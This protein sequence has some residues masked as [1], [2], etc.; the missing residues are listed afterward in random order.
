V[1]TLTTTAAVRSYWGS[2][3][4]EEWLRVWL[5]GGASEDHDAILAARLDDAEAV[6]LSMLSSRY[7]REQLLAA[8]PPQMLVQLIMRQARRELTAKMANLPDAW[9]LDFKALEKQLVDLARGLG[10]LGLPAAPLEDDPRSAVAVVARPATR[11]GMSL[12]D[13]EDW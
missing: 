5:P 9:L 4:I 7:P 1:A 12:A 8:D 6:V 13:T 11:T 3:Q 10:S 2:P